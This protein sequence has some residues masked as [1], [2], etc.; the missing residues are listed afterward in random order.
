MNKVLVRFIFENGR[1][2]T[3]LVEET[4][5]SRYITVFNPQKYEIISNNCKEGELG[6]LLP[7]IK[8]TPITL[9]NIFSPETY[10]VKPFKHNQKLSLLLS[11]VLFY[12]LIR[13]E[14]LFKKKIRYYI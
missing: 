10:Y 4:N 6:L 14:Y 9:K 3:Q 12:E 11:Y 5:L 7:S 1:E 8:G 13:G 2:M